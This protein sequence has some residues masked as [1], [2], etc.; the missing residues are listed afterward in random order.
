[1]LVFQN[2]HLVMKKLFLSFASA[3]D[4]SFDAIGHYLNLK[5]FFIYGNDVSL[6]AACPTWKQLIGKLIAPMVVVVLLICSFY[7]FEIILYIWD[8]GFP[9]SYENIGSV[10]FVSATD[11]SFEKKRL[12]FLKLKRFSI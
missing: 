6:E 12:F 10:F 8:V 3:T 9:N 5:M 11:C 4:C 2:V 1:M 7:R